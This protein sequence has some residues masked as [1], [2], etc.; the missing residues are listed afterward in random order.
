MINEQSWRIIV[1]ISFY[2]RTY[3]SYV[4]VL[5]LRFSYRTG[6]TVCSSLRS[7]R[8]TMK[9]TFELCLPVCILLSVTVI[10]YIGTRIGKDRKNILMIDFNHLVFKIQIIKL[11]CENFIKIGVHVFEKKVNNGFY[12]SY[13]V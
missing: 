10:Q 6:E 3:I 12:F 2:I 9:Q 7:K 5:K 1:E 11:T 8:I 13:F 4:R